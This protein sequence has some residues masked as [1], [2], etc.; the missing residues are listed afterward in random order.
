MDTQI[1]RDLFNAVIKSCEILDSDKDF[2]EKIIKMLEKLP[3]NSIGKHGQIMEWPEDYEEA[4]PGHRHISHLYGLYPSWQFNSEEL[5]SAARKTLERRLANGGGHTGWSRAW[6]ICMWARL[7]EGE[8]VRENLRLLL[9][10]STS[11]NLFDMH[12]PF[13][14]DGN[15]GSIA[16]IAEALLQSQ[17]DVYDL[18]PAMPDNW[19]NGEVRGIRARGG[20]EFD[21]KWQDKNIISFKIKGGDGR[22]VIYKNKNLS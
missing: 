5:I 13:Q 3:E 9:A 16:G 1:L 4:E 8:K 21:I 7:L 19:Q 15:F 14:I 10:N 2:A 12:P 22:P 20:A 17:G 11:E 6:I 18:L